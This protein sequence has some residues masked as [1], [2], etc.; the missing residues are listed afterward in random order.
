VVAGTVAPE[1]SPGGFDRLPP[2]FDLFH[3]GDK[4]RARK[5]PRVPKHRFRR[6][7]QGGVIL[8]EGQA[9]DAV[10]EDGLEIFR[11]HPRGQP[12]PV[13]AAVHAEGGRC[14][15]RMPIRR[16]ARHDGGTEPGGSPAKN[17]HQLGNGLVRGIRQGQNAHLPPADGQGDGFLGRSPDH[18]TVDT[19]EFQLRAAAQHEGDVAEVVPAGRAERHDQERRGR[20][21]APRQRSRPEH[22]AVAFVV[23]KDP[24]I[25]RCPADVV[26]A[27]LR[28][29]F[30]RVGRK[31][32]QVDDPDFPVVKGLA[33]AHWFVSPGVAF[34]QRKRIFAA[35]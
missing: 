9:P 30:Q 17:L 31:G 12:H 32:R 21:K 29:K 35:S 34:C 11:G 33:E 25:Q 5:R 2:A 22:E 6:L 23:R 7:G 15:R 24:G 27:G 28:R 4:P 14:M 8:A 3:D 26:P 19:R 20:G 16:G 18:E 10:E 13:G 1:L